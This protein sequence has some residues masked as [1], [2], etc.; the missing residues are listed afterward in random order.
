M[1]G[2]AALGIASPVPFDEVQEITFSEPDYGTEATLGLSI[3][4][5]T[6]EDPSVI[7][8][9][10]MM[11]GSDAYEI[12]VFVTVNVTLVEGEV[13]ADDLSTLNGR[14]W[15]GKGEDGKAAQ[16][17]NVIGSFEPCDGFN[18]DAIAELTETGST[19]IC[20]VILAQ[21]DAEIATVGFGSN[22]WER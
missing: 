7:E 6:V 22:D 1:T 5:A 13:G 10:G 19:E 20:T 15:H 2:C 8:S 14:S 21:T 4:D 3:V 18:R 16:G 9:L 11:S 17:L 12:P